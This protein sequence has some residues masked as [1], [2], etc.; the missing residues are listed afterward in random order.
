MHNIKKSLT[1][2]IGLIFGIAIQI[3]YAKQTV[4]Y[5]PNDGPQSGSSDDVFTWNQTPVGWKAKSFFITPNSN[6]QEPVR[7]GVSHQPTKSKY[8]FYYADGA[9]NEST[10]ANQVSCTYVENDPGNH[11]LILTKTGVVPKW[12][13]ERSTMGRCGSDMGHTH[14]F[15]CPFLENSK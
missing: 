13:Y 5:C 6:Y 9:A 10:T 11:T 1:L 2:L 14:V 12:K 15:D 7:L 8:T 4:G 3:T